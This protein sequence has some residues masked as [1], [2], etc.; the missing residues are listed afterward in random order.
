MLLLGLLLIGH[1]SSEKL[2]SRTLC[3]WFSKS[4]VTYSDSQARLKIK[5]SRPGNKEKKSLG[6]VTHN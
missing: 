5:D 3:S 4:K 2:S 1:Y 6:G